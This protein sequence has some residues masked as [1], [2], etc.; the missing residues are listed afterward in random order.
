MSHISK[1]ELEVNELNTLDSACKRLGLEL[2]KGQKNFKWFGQ[3][4]GDCDHAIRVPEA[5][6]EIG[7]TR[8]NGIYEL[9]CDYYDRNIGTAIGEKGGLLKQAYAVEKTKTEARRKG[10]LAIEKQ[11]DTG[12]RLHVRLN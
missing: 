1:I 11:T 9:E 2:V 12:I 7:I 4:T 8:V 3:K 5:E 6:Y 10:Y